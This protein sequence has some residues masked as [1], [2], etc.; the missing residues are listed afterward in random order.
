M[1]PRVVSAPR[2]GNTGQPTISLLL[3][4]YGMAAWQHPLYWL[5]RQQAY[6]PLFPFCMIWRSHG[7]P[8]TKH[9]RYSLSWLLVVPSSRLLV[10]FSLLS[11]GHTTNRASRSPL[12]CIVAT[13][14]KGTLLPLLLSPRNRSRL[15]LCL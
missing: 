7:N 9:T 8:T 14:P 6:P 10:S 1:P 12:V 11:V 4:C 15:P 13:Q 3:S 2:P 5:A